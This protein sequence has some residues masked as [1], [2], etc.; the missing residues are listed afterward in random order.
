MVYLSFFLYLVNQ[1]SLISIPL[2]K[3]DGKEELVPQDVYKLTNSAPI[4]K[5]FE[6]AKNIGKNAYDVI[7]GRQGLI[8]G[9]TNLVQLK[10]QGV[11]G[12][13]LLE[14]ALSG[15]GINKQTILAAGGPLMDGAAEYMGINPEIVSKV[16]VST[17]GITRIVTG[18]KE[19]GFKSLLGIAG[20]LT[21][22]P[23]MLKAIDIGMESAVW[24]SAISQ[25]VKYNYPEMM[26]TV[27]NSVD[28]EVMYWSMVYASD[29]VMT[30]GN[31]ESHLVMLQTLTPEVTLG[32]NPDYI[33]TFLSAFKISPEWTAAEYPA[34]ALLLA[35]QMADM[36]PSWTT[37]KRTAHPFEVINLEALAGMSPDAKKL[38]SYIEA[39]KDP[40]QMAGNFPTTTSYNLCRDQYPMSVAAL[41]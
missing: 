34:K 8:N 16:K 14:N 3:T 22:D 36:N 6:A 25:A 15:W 5:V 27:N 29:T 1:M 37:Y 32:H 20:S 28:P 19:G 10:Q 7:G 41:K 18:D 2:F 30:Q 31:L 39:L 21:G 35:Q 26:Y 38:L 24:G 11:T 33:K 13:A 4:N 40:I 12:K 17:D 23:T 9:V